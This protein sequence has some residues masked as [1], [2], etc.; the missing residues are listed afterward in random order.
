[1]TNYAIKNMAI[2]G[3]RLNTNG[4]PDLVPLAPGYIDPVYAVKSGKGFGGSSPVQTRRFIFLDA[5]GSND[6]AIGGYATVA[7]YVAADA[8]CCAARK[9]AGADA[10]IRTTL[11]PRNDGLMTE[12]NRLAF[13]ALVPTITTYDAIADL[14][15]QVTMGNPLTCSNTTYYVDGIHPTSLGYSLI[16]PIGLAAVKALVSAKGWGSD[17]I[18]LIAGGDSITAQQDSYFYQAF[19]LVPGAYTDQGQTVPDVVASYAYTGYYS[20]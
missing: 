11:L 4:F 12:P 2:S 18:C 3:T 7:D 20:G 6:G 17:L 1:M 16:A 10:V 5:I 8:A 13:N 14:A 19:S 9:T 15:S